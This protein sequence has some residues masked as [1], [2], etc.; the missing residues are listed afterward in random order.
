[1]ARQTRSGY[2]GTP[3][4]AK[5]GIEEGS[6]VAFVAAPSAF[7]DVLGEL[8]PG[9]RI[10]PKAKDLDVAIVFVLRAAELFDKFSSAAARA[11]PDGSVWIAWPKKTSKVVTDMTE[12]EIRR[13]LLP[14]G[15]VDNKVC[16]IDEV[17]S[18]LRMVLRK[19]LRPKKR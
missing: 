11:K 1:M 17:W 16:A 2:S 10:S 13:Q 8:P 14:T 9:A 5:L 12:D 19:E 6:V 4:P 15:W 18:G 3:L 7:A